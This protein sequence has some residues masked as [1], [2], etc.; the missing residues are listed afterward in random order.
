MVYDV[1]IDGDFLVIEEVE[2]DKKVNT[3]SWYLDSVIEFVIEQD[4]KLKEQ[5]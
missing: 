1:H 5:D 3:I 2:G 4:K